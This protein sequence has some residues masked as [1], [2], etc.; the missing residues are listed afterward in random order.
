MDF[1]QSFDLDCRKFFNLIINSK[2]MLKMTLKPQ[3]LWSASCTSGCKSYLS[4]ILCTIEP[5]MSRTERS[6]SYLSPYV[7]I[8]NRL[9]LKNGPIHKFSLRMIPFPCPTQKV[10][11]WTT[12]ITTWGSPTWSR[13]RL[14]KTHNF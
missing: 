14:S 8:N 5:W 11:R 13:R 12:T 2:F 4:D 3:F 6:I 1:L 10:T 7:L 9:K